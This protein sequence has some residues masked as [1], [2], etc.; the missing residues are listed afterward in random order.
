VEEVLL[1]ATRRRSRVR[2]RVE[3]EPRRR[4]GHGKEENAGALHAAR[5][6]DERAWMG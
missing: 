2:R 6:E 3:E 1:G 4:V 5:F